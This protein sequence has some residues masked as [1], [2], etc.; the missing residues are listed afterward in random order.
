MNPSISIPPTPAASWL[1]R[2]ESYASWVLVL[3]LLISSARLTR[4]A[5]AAT[6]AAVPF[7][8]PMHDPGSGHGRKVTVLFD[9]RQY[10]GCVSIC[11]T[12]C[13]AVPALQSPPSGQRR[14]KSHFIG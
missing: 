3:L 6:A 8:L 14:Q 12:S 7:A 2:T 1:S 4:R 5:D 11:A 9:A 10:C 13:L